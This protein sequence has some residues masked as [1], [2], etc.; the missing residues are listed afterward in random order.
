MATFN[1]VSVLHNG[2]KIASART[3]E[4]AP[5]P[6]AF[7]TLN[8]PDWHVTIGPTYLSQYLQK[9]CVVTATRNGKPYK[10][11]YKL[12]GIILGGAGVIKLSPIP[13]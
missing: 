3:G 10:A 13:I 6:A 7:L 1:D 8:G 2:K 4:V 5:P 11:N 12:T 9:T